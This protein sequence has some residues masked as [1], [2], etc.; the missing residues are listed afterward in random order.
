MKSI[1]RTGALLFGVL[2][3]AA[4]PA[5][6]QAWP[7][8]PVRIIAPFAP[9]GAAD[10]LGRLV[11][12]QLTTLLKQQFY[13]E[14]RG[15]A[16]GIV[17][18]LAGAQAEPDGYT[19]V[20]SSIASNVISPVFNANVGYDGVKDFTH[21]AYL[22]GPP[23]VM[24]VHPSLKLKTFREFV[25]FAR[26]SKDPITYISPGTGSHG[27]LVAE[28][29]AQQEK[30]RL[31]HVPY[32]GAG[33]AVADLIAGHVKMGNTTFS[34][35]VEQIRSKRVVP[36]AV[37]TEKRI[38]EF[39]SLPTF[40]EQ[41]LDL[42]A[43]TWFSL[44]GPKGLPNDIAQRLNVEVNKAMKADIV[45]KRLALDSIESRFMSIEEFNKFVVQ[46]N[47]RWAPIAKQLSAIV[48]KK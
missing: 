21:I 30:Y 18:A 23:S 39:P 10:T 35:M 31:S 48:N 38:S 15:G 14:N 26:K 42:V 41:G 36:L 4:G 28:Y 32:K 20:V 7:N 1:A 40:K 25:D 13:V 19:L 37:T 33:P 22:G 45:Q 27:F 8:K 44:S 24:V 46:E 16:G 9:G 34:S 47:A 11:A 6:A 5:H 17:G 29:V 12:D 2:C 3:L 43:A